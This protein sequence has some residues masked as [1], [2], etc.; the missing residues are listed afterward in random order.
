[1]LGTSAVPGADALPPAV[2]ANSGGPSSRTR[3]ERVTMTILGRDD[4]HVR[5]RRVRQIGLY[6][7]LM[8]DPVQVMTRLLRRNGSASP[9]DLR[10][11]FD[12][13]PGR[14]IATPLP[15][16][17]HRVNPACDDPRLALEHAL[18]LGLCTQHLYDPA[19]PVLWTSASL[20]RVLELFDPAGFYA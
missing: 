14:L 10:T 7:D 6:F 18:L 20:W 13:P 17:T 19:R 5:C 11:E 1:M 15:L 2:W 4:G 3:K 12:L 8:D 9:E 16:T